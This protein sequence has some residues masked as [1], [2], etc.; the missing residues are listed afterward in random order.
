MYVKWLSPN[1][2]IVL[3]PVLLF[4]SWFSL[5]TLTALIPLPRTLTFERR[6]G[7]DEGNCA[8]REERGMRVLKFHIIVFHLP[9][10]MESVY[11]ALASK[12]FNQSYCISLFRNCLFVTTLGIGS[13]DTRNALTLSKPSVVAVCQTMF[14]TK[15]EI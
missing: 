2:R 11:P 1:S 10:N 4:P 6:R 9:S 14:Y 13:H 8:R 12:P 5:I 15:T 7:E 3:I